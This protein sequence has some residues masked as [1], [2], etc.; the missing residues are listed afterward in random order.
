M[1]PVRDRGYCYPAKCNVADQLFISPS[2]SNP[3]PKN[4]RKKDKDDSHTDNLVV[5]R[6]YFNYIRFRVFIYF[7]NL[8]GTSINSCPHLTLLP[9]SSRPVLL[10]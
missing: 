8:L 2:N 4:V 5:S 3:T 9:K 1:A 6:L 7:I 10:E